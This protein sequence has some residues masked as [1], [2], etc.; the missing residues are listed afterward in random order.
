MKPLLFIDFG[1]TYTKITAVDLENESVIGT[2]SSFSTVSSDINDGLENAQ[3]I[4]YKQTG[5]R[6]YAEK[7]AC[8]SAAGGLRMIACGLVTELTAKAAGLA[9]LGAG[10]KLVKTYSYQLTQSDIDEIDSLAPDIFLLTGG[11]DGGNRDCIL[12]NAGMLSRCQK[13]F[14]IVIAGNRSCGDECAALIGSREVYCTAN[15]M[16]AFGQIDILPA[17]EKI[18]EIFL[19]SIIRAKGL[20]KAQ[21]LISGI[22][23]PTPAAVLEA[24]RL[25]A[26][27]CDG[28]RGIGDLI[29]ADLG[30]ATTDIYSVSDGAPDNFNTII[31]GLPEPRVKRSV[32]GDIG[33]RYSINGILL[34]S[35]AGKLASLSC[36][37]EN[38]V[39]ELAEFYAQN[40]EKIPDTMELINYDRA[41]AACAV[42]TALERHAGTLRQTYT[43]IG[44]AFI[45]TGKNLRAVN[46]FILTG[47]ALISARSPDE[48]AA[49]ALENQNPSVLTPVSAK[50]LVDRKYILA[51]MGLL[52]RFYPGAAL[53]I[54][55]K[56]V[57]GYA[58]SE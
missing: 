21:S 12:H 37:S 58:A 47:G 38:R 19:R 36:L 15:V 54:M 6:D 52:A 57:I 43:P 14:P 27:G 29:C 48:I 11:T 25:L 26:D 17:Q 13:N 3:N 24:V 55:K 31:K 46:T 35:G 30:G 5:I 2:A 40:T 45:Q 8:S 16:P 49:L 33:M 32:E 51:S 34:A 18:R 44:E 23:L 42:K 7:Y 41:L 4:L 28:E 10:A 20:S 53:R 9:A 56:E 39:R 1:S 22:V 50:V